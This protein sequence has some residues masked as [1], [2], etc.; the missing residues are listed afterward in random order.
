MLHLTLFCQKIHGKNPNVRGGGGIKPGGPNSQIL[1]KICF[2]SSPKGGVKTNKTATI[3][4]FWSPHRINV[5]ST[6]LSSRWFR[7]EAENKKLWP[8]Y[9]FYTTLLVPF[10]FETRVKSKLGEMVQESVR[11]TINIYPKFMFNLMTSR[12]SMYFLIA[13]TTA[14]C[15]TLKNFQQWDFM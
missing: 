7:V 8:D 2:W 1:L 12:D 5:D 9:F 13:K 6:H 15:E 10:F 3:F 4:I 11:V 14:F